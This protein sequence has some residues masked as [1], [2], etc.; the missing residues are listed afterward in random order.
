M[1]IENL[2]DLFDGAWPVVHC[3]VRQLAEQLYSQANN[4]HVARATIE[5]RTLGNNQEYGQM[6]KE[7]RKWEKTA[8]LPLEGN[9]QQFEPQRIRLFR[10]FFEP[11]HV[12]LQ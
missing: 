4:G 3:D 6:L 10:A 7:K 1:R 9:T 2:R 11:M 5:E 12:I 8:T